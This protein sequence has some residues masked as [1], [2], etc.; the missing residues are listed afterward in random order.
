[1]EHST[2]RVQAALLHGVQQLQGGAP[3]KTLLKGYKT[4]GLRKVR[5][6]LRR[7]QAA[8]NNII[9]VDHLL[10]NDFFGMETDKISTHT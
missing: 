5:K 9:G 2:Q 3:G 10:S 7:L 8:R 4:W 6:Q 1:M